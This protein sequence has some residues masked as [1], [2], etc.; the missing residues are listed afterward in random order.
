MWCSTG[1]AGTCLPRL[2]ERSDASSPGVEDGRMD[3][4]A[5]SNDTTIE[6]RTFDEINIGD[7]ACITRTLTQEDIELFGIASSDVNTAC[8][9]TGLF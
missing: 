9:Q 4:I 2:R 6:N 7:T 3:P 5:R 1:S 8:V